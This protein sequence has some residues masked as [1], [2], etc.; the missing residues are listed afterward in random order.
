VELPTVLG[1]GWALLLLAAYP[2][3]VVALRPRTLWRAAVAGA[4]LVYATALVAVTMFP[5][6]VVPSSWRAAEH[7]WD[8][9]R[10]V[11][12]VVPPVGFG[13]NIVMFMPFGVLVPLLWPR[14]GTIRRVFGWGLASSAVIEFSQLALWIAVGNRR[15]WDVNDLYSNTL[16]A[17]FGFVL[18]RALLPMTRWPAARR[19][20]DPDP[21]LAEP[22]RERAAGGA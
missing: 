19:T 13:L 16:G 22:A 8:V 6:Y 3:A 5:L 10:L 2:F 12:F 7:W 9:L 17:V 14:L 21:A 20:G 15:Y 18:F 4:L 11:P 1:R